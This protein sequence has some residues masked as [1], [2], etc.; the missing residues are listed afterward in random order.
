MRCTAPK[1]L[2]L[3]VAT[4]AAVLLGGCVSVRYVRAWEL[5]GESFSE[6]L[7][8]S[9]DEFRFER[10]SRLGRSLFLGRFETAGEEWRFFLEGWKP[11][12]SVLWMRFQPPLVY[13]YRGHLFANG[14][15]FYSGIVPRDSPV[16]VFIRVP[17]DFDVA[18]PGVLTSAAG[19]ST[20]QKREVGL[21]GSGGG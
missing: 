12:G 8:L 5:S 15:A 19:V 20:V 17:C 3:A 21:S 7:E 13:R 1:W 4:I 18:E 11:A 6:T 16:E 14:I 9:G 10:T 2:P